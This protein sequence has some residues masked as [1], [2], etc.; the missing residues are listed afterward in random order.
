VG[1][2]GG[3]IALGDSPT[4]LPGVGPRRAEDLARLGVTQAADLLTLW[5]R[6]YQDRTAVLPIA[7]APLDQPVVIQAQVL[8]VTARHAP[9]R[10]V[11]AVL[12]VT[13]GT[14]TL[15]VVFFHARHLLD[16]FRPGQ[17]LLLTGRLERRGRRVSMAHPEWEIVTGSDIRRIVPVYPLAGDLRQAWIRDL[18]QRVVPTLAVQV[19]DPLPE[20]LLHERNL[21]SR[22]WSLRT[23]H[24]PDSMEDQE[25]ARS[26]L[27][28]EEVL[29]VALAV[30]WLRRR[31][32][33]PGQGH[34]LVP[35]GPTARR[36]RDLLPFQLTPAQERA[37]AQIAEDLRRAAPMARLLQGDVGSGKTVVAT[38]ACLAAVDAG[39]QAAFMAPT[40]VLADQL[41]GVLAA[42]LE[43]LG[44]FVGRLTG[45]EG[46]RSGLRRAVASGE[47]P[48]VVGTQALIQESVQFE[49]L[50]LVVVDEQHRFGVRQRAGLSA[51]GMA[52]HL[53]VMT[54]TPI[55]RS[56]ALTLYG[57]LAMTTIDSL[58]P[59]RK[60]VETVRRTRAQRRAVY[61]EVMQA[62][63]R[64]EQAYVVCPFV[65][66]READGARAATAVYEGMRRMGGWRV[67]LI[68]GRQPAEEKSR[69]MDAFRRHAIDVLVATTIIEVG[70]DVPNA[71]VMVVEDADRFGLAQLHQLRGRV[72]R[73]SKPGTCIL[74][75]DPGT[76]DAEARLEALTRLQDGLALAEVDLALRGPGEILGIR[77]HGLAGFR[78]ANPLKDLALMQDARSLAER[79]LARDPD[80]ALPE[81]RGLREACLK[82]LGEQLPASVLH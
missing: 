53:L 43:P 70:V 25:R 14:G 66:E 50:G 47:V 18:M 6:R 51:K 31:E 33:L 56:L 27:V 24:W 13:D 15:D 40:E 29:V 21:P 39:L 34:A 81:H 30:Q 19:A 12:T 65:E 57:D 79:V 36:L 45:R 63:R 1:P 67:G 72:G 8:A 60:P 17:T 23:V 16:R 48:V 62:V 10:D 54:A 28:L 38:L 44:V 78:L 4:K 61:E 2:R 59:G 26:R 37:W 64:G 77:Q 76:E 41:A 68:H 3:G 69:V 35:D 20:W 73:G 82:A 71:T 46:A 32:A 42:W 80:L 49:R 58:P 55:P 11:M 7:W 22:S 74:V 75:A 52:P 5:P 9:G